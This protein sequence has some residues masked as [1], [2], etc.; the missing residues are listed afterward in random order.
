MRA[1]SGIRSA[2]AFRSCS[3]MRR[4]R[5]NVRR[6]FA[7]FAVLAVSCAL[8]LSSGQSVF[9]Q[10]G[11]VDEGAKDLIR[12]TGAR[13]V[14]MGLAVTAGATGSE[15]LWANPALIAR[16]RREASLHLRGKSYASDAD[17]DITGVVIIPWQNVGVIAIGLRYLDY[18]SQ[19]VT[20]GPTTPVGLIKN[21]NIILTATAATT[22]G[23]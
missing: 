8:A 11:L 12:P 5:S 2:M 1:S 9:A 18:G 20:S 17:G 16:A 21:T 10:S 23:R 15:A 14:G 13:S 22:F 3:S 19:D 6:S 4:R 7:I